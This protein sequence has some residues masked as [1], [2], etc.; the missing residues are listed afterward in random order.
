MVHLRAHGYPLD[1]SNSDEVHKITETVDPDVIAHA[2]AMTD[3]DACETE[4]EAATE[5]N[6]EGTQNVIDA[7]R[8]V[9]SDVVFLSTS[10]VFG[11]AGHP[12]TTDARRNP[13][14]EYG[15]TKATAERLVESVSL[16][17]PIV[18]T[19]QPYGWSREWQTPT[20]VEWTLGQLRDSDSVEVFDDWYN[21]P[22]Y[23]PDLAAVVLRLVQNDFDGVVHAVGPDFVSRFEWTRRIA[24]AFGFDESTVTGVSSDTVYLPARRPSVELDTGLIEEVVDFV[25]R[26]MIA[27]FE[28]MRAD[29]DVE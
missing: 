10:F 16:R 29:C 23:L 18:R 27:G 21:N 1:V 9:Q 17:T 28:T 13:V 5:V 25:P 12:H 15:R 3:V 24:A 20:M 6:V 22:T 7:S 14:N 2:A 4:P 8:A 26:S 11:G 19:D